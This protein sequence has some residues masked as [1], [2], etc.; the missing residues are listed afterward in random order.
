MTVETHQILQSAI[1][2]LEL[3]MA[4]DALRELDRLAPDAR[5]SVEALELASVLLQRLGRWADAAAAY[6]DLARIDPDNIERYIARGCC[7]Y[8]LGRVEECREA[9]LAAPPAARDH[10]LWNFH[11]ACYEAHLGRADEARRLVQRSLALDPRLA[12]MA[13]RNSRLGPLLA[14]L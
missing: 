7:L 6:A 11:L 3:G 5:T 9:L 14:A 2:Y 4:E 8:E 13:R 10:A 1:G 12:A